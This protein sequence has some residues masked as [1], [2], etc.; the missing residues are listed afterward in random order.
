MKALLDEESE[1][2]SI[3]EE[4]ENQRAKVAT[5]TPMTTELFFQWR[6][7]KTEE[8]DAKL[9][10]QQAERAKNDRMS[11]R[12]LFL[13][14]ASL[15][16]DD[17]EAYDQYQREPETEQKAAEEGPSSSAAAGADA[18]VPDPDDDDDELDLDELNELEASL[19]KTSIQI[20]E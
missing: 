8:R 17:D 18:E 10:S 16:V 14:D 13:S 5:T 9:A 3:E 1:K 11:G 20:K 7:K 19:S 4:I 15:F 2:I 12:E 6:K